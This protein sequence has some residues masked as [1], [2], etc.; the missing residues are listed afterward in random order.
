MFYM[1]ML[2]L[3]CSLYN[4]KV[5]DSGRYICVATSESGTIREYVYLEVQGFGGGEGNGKFQ[6][7]IQT[8][9]V[10]DQVLMDCLVSGIVT[11]Q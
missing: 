5:R 4:I 2:R 7:Q 6:E 1:Y 3:V 9:S 11:V 10:G 8:V